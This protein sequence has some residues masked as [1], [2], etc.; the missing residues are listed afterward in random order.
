MIVRSEKTLEEFRTEGPCELCGLWCPRREPHHVGSRG[1]AGGSRLDI[2]EALVGLCHPCHALKGDDP[3][4]LST[5]LNLIAVRERFSSGDEVQAYLWLVLRTP[6]HQPMPAA[7][8][9]P[10]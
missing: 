6:K 7:P 4:F 1:H 8:V 10:F 2:R 5:F 9:C 3:R